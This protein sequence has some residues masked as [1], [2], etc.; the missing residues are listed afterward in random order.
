MSF[1]DCEKK[2]LKPAAGENERPTKGTIWAAELRARC[3]RL[4][5]AERQE[6]L[7]RAMRLIY[8]DEAKPAQTRR[9]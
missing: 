3:N 9:G 4:S 7:G 8:G 6:L 5:D 1:W 2:L